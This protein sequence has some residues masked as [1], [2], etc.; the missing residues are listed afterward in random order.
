MKRTMQYEDHKWATIHT[1][2]PVTPD[3]LAD[4]AS[5]MRSIVD[6]TG[7]PVHFHTDYAGVTLW[8]PLTEEDKEQAAQEQAE[9]EERQERNRVEYEAR[10]LERDTRAADAL[11]VSVNEYREAKKKEWTA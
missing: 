3:V 4:I 5:L 6:A 1:A 7:R 11:G 2:C 8:S 9:A 10:Q